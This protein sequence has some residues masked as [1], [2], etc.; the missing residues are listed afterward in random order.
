MSPQEEDRL[1]AQAIA[2]S[3][4]MR[5]D[6]AAAHRTVRYLEREQLEALACALGAMV[7]PNCPLP[8]MAWWRALP[9]AREAA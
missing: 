9:Q 5:E 2:F 8:V 7:D 1:L 3:M 4:D 6:L